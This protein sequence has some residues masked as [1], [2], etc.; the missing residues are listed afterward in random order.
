MTMTNRPGS[1]LNP[2]SPSDLTREQR[3]ALHH[4]KT[5]KNS[6]P[7]D[8]SA[9]PDLNI[10][11]TESNRVPD[12]N[13]AGDHPVATSAGTLGGA[14]AGAAIGSVG[15]PAGAVVGGLVGG[16]VGGLAGNEAAEAA[17][18]TVDTPEGIAL[19]GTENLQDDDDHYWREQYQHRPYYSEA[20]TVYSDLDYDRDYRGAYRLGHEQ[21]SHYDHDTDFDRAE[22]NL[23]QKWEQAKGESRLSWEQAKFAVKDAWDRITR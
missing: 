10:P 6:P 22:P 1:D 15:G 16:V 2:D 20:R 9:R 13:E 11:N 17:R 21:R 3:E 14:A 18:P 8:E 12:M 19:S 7:T 4:E 5:L 23:R